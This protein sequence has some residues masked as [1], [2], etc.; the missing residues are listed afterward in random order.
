M[1]GGVGGLCNKTVTDPL[2]QDQVQHSPHLDSALD[3]ALDTPIGFY[4]IINVNSRDNR[5]AAEAPD[6]SSSAL[7]QASRRLSSMHDLT[8]LQMNQSAPYWPSRADTYKQRM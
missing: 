3:S 6:A 8:Q 1:L 2:Q 7:H 4:C 5:N